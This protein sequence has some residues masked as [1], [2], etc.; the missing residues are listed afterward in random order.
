[1]P[2]EPGYD[3]Q[4]IARILAILAKH[5]EGIWLR[6]LAQESGMTHATVGKYV[7][8]PL[9]P[10]VEVTALGEKPLLKVV[11]LKPAVQQKLGEGLTLE[12]V[13]RLMNLIGKV[14]KES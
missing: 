8:G 9:A 12:Q 10:V 6:K 3:P 2:R 1:M 14:V 13:M 7:D 11:R 4:R 5:P